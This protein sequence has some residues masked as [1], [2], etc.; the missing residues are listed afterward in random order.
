MKLL[1]NILLTTLPLTLA[2]GIGCSSDNGNTGPD[3]DSC[4]GDKCDDLDLPDSEVADSP[5]DGI[6]ID[7]SGRG[8]AKVAA[9]LD[10][11]LANFVF[12]TGEDCPVT[13]QDI[14]AKLRLNDT[15]GCADEE[16]GISTRAVSET[17]QAAGEATSYR[18]VTSRRCGGRDT[19]ELVFSLFGIR[20]GATALPGGVEVMAFDKTAGVFNYYE[21]DGREVHFFGNSH[22][23]A[24]G[25]QG[26]VR[27][28]A[29]CHTG[30][31]LI[32]KEL[33]TPWVHW[34]GHMD[35]PGAREL[36]DAHAD[37]GSRAT[38]SEFEGVVK[39]GNKAWNET[40]LASLRENSSLKEALRP[41]FC[42]VEVNLDNGADFESP[43]EGGEGGSEMSRIGFDSLLD[44]QLKGFGSISVDF[45]DYDAAIKA[46]GQRIQGI[47][48]AIDT[49]FDYVFIERAHADN[50]YVDKLEAAGLINEEFIKD[51]LMVDFTRPIFSA[52]RCDLLEFAPVLA[53]ADQNPDSIRKGFLDNLGNPAAGT[54][55]AE[56]KN[57]LL[58]EGGH[59]TAIDAY[60]TAC[61]DLGSPALVENALQ[62]TSL[63]RATASNLRV[64]EFPQTMPTDNLSVAQGSRLSPV[65]C[66]VTTA[67][68]AVTAAVTNPEPEP[69]PEPE[70]ATCAHDVCVE[71]EAL[72]TST[73]P[74]DTCVAQICEADAFCCNNTWDNLCVEQ[75]QSV[76]MQECS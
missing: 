7:E 3:A 24:K 26:N 41:L 76:C 59:D 57:N 33:D 36:I 29:A 74:E 20:A 14:M 63:N 52:D 28:C 46:N 19:H 50:D 60:T 23:M 73:C 48:G 17:A 65:D 4:R 56:L 25:A 1:K 22:D 51:V 67:F 21:T 9:R 34:E 12:K 75:V 40:R 42:T 58:T 55:E 68:T 5:C 72:T 44:P 62:I 70:P 45:A 2:F 61:T 43:V 13:F 31:G 39:K 15:E 6:M 27:R 32:M 49:V 38:G 64:F 69:E 10:D 30:G 8:N 66:N 47:P 53:S 37:L 54:P 71:G 35:I 11:P 18:L 16:S